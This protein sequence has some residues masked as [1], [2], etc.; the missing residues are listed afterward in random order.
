MQTEN[1]DAVVK[2]DPSQDIVT[3]VSMDRNETNLEIIFIT[4]DVEKERICFKDKKG[5]E[6]FLPMSALIDFKG[7]IVWEDEENF[8]EVAILNSFDDGKTIGCTGKDVSVTFNQMDI[9]APPPMPPVF[10]LKAA[11]QDCVPDHFAGMS[12]MV[13]R[14]TR[15]LCYIIA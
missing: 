5:T 12:V 15:V 13:H 3:P 10:T 14:I 7:I 9:M 2:E 6:V 11:S 4:R 1:P 8:L